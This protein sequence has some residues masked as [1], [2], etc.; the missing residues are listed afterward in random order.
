MKILD[1]YI[2]FKFLSTFVFIIGLLSGITVVIDLSEKI[3]NLIEHEAGFWTTLSEYYIYFIPYI[4]ALLGPF[5]VLVAVI[6]FTSQL[7]ERSEIIAILN[8]GTN[9]YRLL[10]P[11]GMGA[12]LLA[13]VLGISNHYLVPFSNKKRIEF[14]RK[15][16]SRGVSDLRFSFHRMI[17]PGTFIYVENYKPSERSGFRFSLERFS[18][19]KLQTKLK[20]ERIE[21]LP[22]EN[23]WRLHDVF[24]RQI[25]QEK[26][27]HREAATADS[28][29]S[30]TPDDFTFTESVKEV[31]TTPELDLFITL[32][33]KSGQSDSIYYQIERHRRSAS[34]FSVLIMTLIG[35]SVASR[36]VRGGLGWHLVLG[37]GLSAL[38]EIIMKF[39]T[40]FSANAGLPAIMGV[41]I[42]NFVYLIMAIGLLL[43]A[44]K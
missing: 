42:P 16:V 15:Y 18:N 4:T 33:N 37:I 23:K 25:M 14:E 5:F 43:R 20:A 13:A 17:G 24:L 12:I 2:L 41:W 36:K 9:F 35:L 1:R 7:A 27:F 32:L 34:A 10:I 44:P 26:E 6:F 40:T 8:S 21:W 31:M 22:Q 19:Q 30:F 28:V 39:S 11:Y 3:D 38:Y 29:F